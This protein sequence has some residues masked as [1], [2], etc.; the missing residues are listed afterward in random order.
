MS[1]LTYLEMTL[2]R[3]VASRDGMTWH[4]I[5]R[6]HSASDAPRRPDM[7]VTLK[8]L[9]SRG[10]LEREIFEGSPNDRWTITE[11]GRGAIS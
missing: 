5:A 10:F 4:E 11:L 1:D 9:A 2:L 7:M 6:A 3:I 8:D